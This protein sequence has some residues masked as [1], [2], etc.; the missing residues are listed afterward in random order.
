MGYSKD[1][2]TAPGFYFWRGIGDSDNTYVIRVYT[3]G[4]NPLLFTSVSDPITH[5][6]RAAPVSVSAWR[7]VEWA[8]PIPEPRS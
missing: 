6:P 3:V 5:H 1:A 4:G 7:G 8:G 2:P